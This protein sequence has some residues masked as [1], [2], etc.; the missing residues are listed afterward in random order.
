MKDIRIK[1]KWIKRELIIVISLYVIVNLFNLLAVVLYGTPWQEIYTSQG[2]V[3]Y[4]TEWI[5]I[6]T[7]AIRLLV[8]GVR[9][10][11]KKNQS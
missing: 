5:Y 2:Y 4:F 9:Y 10:V 6:I 3:L 1:W 8:F 7:A 11:L